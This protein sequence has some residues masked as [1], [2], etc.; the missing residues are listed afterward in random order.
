V[1]AVA[2]GRSKPTPV[3]DYRVHFDESHEP[4]AS[5]VTMWVEGPE[6][7]TYFAGNYRPEQ[8]DQIALAAAHAAERKRA[9]LAQALWIAGAAS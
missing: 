5:R 9:E 1:R 8:L 2:Q 6:G 7:G 3:P 4:P